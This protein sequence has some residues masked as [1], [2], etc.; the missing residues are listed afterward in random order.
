M[1][2]VSVVM[3]LPLLWMLSTA[4][5]GDES[6]YAYPPE[7]IPS[8]FHWENFA[9]GIEQAVFWQ[10]FLNSA[11]ITVT[12]TIGQVLSCMIVAYPLA[13]IRFPGRAFWFYCIIGSMM[14]PSMVSFLPVFKVFSAIGW[15]N[16]WLPLI[17]PSWLGGPFYTFLLRQY[18]MTIP[19]SFDEAAKIDGASHLSILFRIIAPMS[20]PAIT[21]IVIGQA[22]ASWSDFFSPLI[23]L[24]DQSK[25][26]L[27]LA[28]ANFTSQYHTVW[29]LFM[30]I[31]LMY[32]LPSVIIF[33][34][35]QRYFMQG[36]GSLNTVGLK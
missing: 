7:W 22:L 36:L 9:R 27:S 24:P 6:I 2:L 10:K 32:M 14:L 17:V 16:T 20:L 35:A 21:V 31:A 28:M 5:K 30:A 25:W 23:Y 4:L 34:V 26:T 3:L 15:Y 12:A 8:T 1:V 11:I 29:N 19:T 13:R 33:F 18:Y